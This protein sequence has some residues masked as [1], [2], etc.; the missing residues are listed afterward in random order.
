ME[1]K[2]TS[3]HHGNKFCFP[4]PVVP[5]LSLHHSFLPPFFPL[6]LGMVR[7]QV[8]METRGIRRHSGS[9][10][11]SQQGVASRHLPHKQ[12]SGPSS[13]AHSSSRCWDVKVKVMGVGI[14]LRHEHHVGLSI[15]VNSNDGQFDV[16]LYVNVLVS[17]DGTVNWL[18]PA[19][20]RSSCSIQVGLS[21]FCLCPWTDMGGF[22][23]SNPYF[24]FKE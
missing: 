18:P 2:E 20:Y 16:A 7:L 15:S 13:V 12:V 24:A 10:H 6:L 11:S 17:S 5:F 23:S 19:I 21:F 1:V 9:T 4:V 14:C 22:S 8:V 3:G